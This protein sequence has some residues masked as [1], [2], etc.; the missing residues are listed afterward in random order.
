MLLGIAILCLATLL[1]WP[2]KWGGQ[3]TYLNL[4]GISM[5]PTLEAGSLAIVRSTNDYQVGDI[6]AYEPPGSTHAFYLHRIREVT[7]DGYWFKGDNNKDDDPRIVKSNQIMGEMLFAIPHAGAIV[8]N[9]LVLLAIAGAILA[10]T[11]GV[12]LLPDAAQP[13]A[14]ARRFADSM[15]E[16]AAQVK[17]RSG[18]VKWGML[19]LA[20]LVL[21]AAAY[22]YITREVEQAPDRV[23]AQ[24]TYSAKAKVSD[25][26]PTG[27]ITSGDTIY[28]RLASD[29]DVTWKLQNASARGLELQL[30]DGQGW[31]R[32]IKLPQSWKG[33]TL[34]AKLDLDEIT[35]LTDQI[36]MQTGVPNAT[37]TVRLK[38]VGAK[39]ARIPSYDFTLNEGVIR[40][41]DKSGLSWSPDVRKDRG[42]PNTP[43]MLSVMLLAAGV[44]L[45]AMGLY[46]S[47]PAP[48]A[49]RLAIGQAP[50]GEWLDLPSSEELEQLALRLDVPIMEH[51]G[52]EYVIVPGMAQ[53]YRCKGAVTLMESV[54]AA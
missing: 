1:A 54:D 13:S 2:A 8:T 16:G 19:S 14:I 29:L 48:R 32:P 21:A 30:R 37:Y 41:A 3:M 9:K 39:G 49:R 53:G 10:L 28:T 33:S 42:N 43:S 46:D 36:Q 51:A 35:K 11:F 50:A 44:A 47:Q 20:A 15:R 45:L 5:K 25:T 26:Y 38:P 6:V 27:R 52:A 17:A 22:T 31:S 12:S 18:E 7:P 23:S 34:H 40:P 24:L 4:D